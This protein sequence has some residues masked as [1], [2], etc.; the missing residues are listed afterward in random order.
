MI[1]SDPLVLTLQ[2]WIGVF[3]RRN[4]RTLIHYLKEN[5]LSMSQIGALFQI[6][7]GKSNVSD[8]GERLGIS[9]AAV[10]QMLDRL[11]EEELI[12]RS[13]DPHDRR[14]KEIILTDKGCRIIQDSVRVRQGLLEKLVAIM[15]DDEK[16][17]IH[18]AIRILIEKTNQLD[19]HPEAD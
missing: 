17:Q 1:S 7:H 5:D 19:I 8:L 15:S 4:M 14:F 2:E 18:A 12:L 10:S 13:E 11:V 6:N 3:M 9:K 16:E